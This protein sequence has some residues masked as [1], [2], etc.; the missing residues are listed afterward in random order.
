M[1][2]FGSD[3]ILFGSG[4]KFQELPIILVAALVIFG[5]K[6][7]VPQ[8]FFKLVVGDLMLVSYYEFVDIIFF[9]SFVIYE[10]ISYYG[11]QLFDLH[12]PR[13]SLPL[14][15]CSSPHRTSKEEDIMHPPGHLLLKLAPNTWG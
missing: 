9:V 12:S 4:F 6:N 1:N 2:L 15:T 10:S 14:V 7:Q 8:V 11:A 3:M 5:V 13:A